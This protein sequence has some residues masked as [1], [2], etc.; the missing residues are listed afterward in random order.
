[1]GLQEEPVDVTMR[2]LRA[3]GICAVISAWLTIAIGI[4]RNPWFVLTRNAFS[5][6]GGPRAADPWIY[7]S[8]MLITAALLMAF[9][10]YLLATSRNGVESMGASFASIAGIF[11]ALI[12]IFHEGT[13]PHAFVS[14]WFFVQMDIAIGIWGIGGVLARSRRRRRI[15]DSRR[16]CAN[17]SADRQVAFI[18]GPRVL[19]NFGH[20]RVGHRDGAARQSA[21]AVSCR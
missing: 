18:S 14:T 12:G 16:R 10:A 1:M 2:V 8:G 3:S 5:D 4:Y 17:H 7:Y 13:Y 11:L 19:R 6:L 9:S 21:S 20:R 15:T